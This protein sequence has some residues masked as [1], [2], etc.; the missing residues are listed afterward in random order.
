MVVCLLIFL[1]SF[2]LGILQLPI[3]ILYLVRL[4]Y[5]CIFLDFLW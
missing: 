1:S 4:F 3:G 2:P 5:F